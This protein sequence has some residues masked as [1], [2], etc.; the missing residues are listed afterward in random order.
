MNGI[1]IRH[2]KDC[3]KP[4]ENGKCCDASFQAHVFD[5]NANGGKG[6]RIR[7]T[8]STKDGAK[9]WRQDALVALRAGDLTADRSPTIQEAAEQWL[10]DARNGHARNRSGDPYKPSA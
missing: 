9:L 10:E 5:K 4:R 1:D 6:K 7:K 2:K 8:F 3:T